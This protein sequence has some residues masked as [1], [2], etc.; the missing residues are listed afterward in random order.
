[1]GLEGFV[2][3]TDPMVSESATER[4]AK[5]SNLTVGLLCCCV[6][7]LPTFRGRLPPAPRVQTTNTLNS[8]VL[9]RRFILAR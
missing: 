1:M 3:W 5:M 7:E 2:N 4:E 6:N 8:L 9:L